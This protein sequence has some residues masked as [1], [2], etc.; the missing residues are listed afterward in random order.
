M[1]E[2]IYDITQEKPYRGTLRLSGYGKYKA[3]IAAYGKT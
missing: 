1:A 2:G 3:N